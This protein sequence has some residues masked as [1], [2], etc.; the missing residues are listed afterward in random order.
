MTGK[1]SSAAKRHCMVVFAHC[2]GSET[3]VQRQAELLIREGFEV[4]VLCL[5]EIGREAPEDVVNGQT[6]TALRPLAPTVGMFA[7]MRPCG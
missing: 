5:R 4:D 6:C 3:R 1:T 2:P 7:L